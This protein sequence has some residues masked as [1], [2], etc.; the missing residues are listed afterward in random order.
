MQAEITQAL[1]RKK[2]PAQ[3]MA[4]AEEQIKRHLPKHRR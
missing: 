4:D 2:T 1:H 3:A